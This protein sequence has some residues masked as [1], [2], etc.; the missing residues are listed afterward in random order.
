MAGFSATV[1][2]SG[3]DR[4]L[5]GFVDELER[6]APRVGMAEATATANAI[7]AGVPRRSG[8]LAG[9]VGAEHT[10]GGG[11]VTYG[12]GLPYAAYIERRAHAVAR[13]LAGAPGRFRSSCA[14]V[15]ADAAARV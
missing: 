10:P 7:R 9:T 2:T 4:A 1:D 3:L 13:A 11:A 6:E 12:G 15:A 8:R 5:A 14:R